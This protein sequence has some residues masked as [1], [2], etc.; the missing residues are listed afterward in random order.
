MCWPGNVDSQWRPA[1]FCMA[2]IRV[3][4]VRRPHR[5]VTGPISN[6]SSS[7]AANA[8]F[9]VWLLCYWLCVTELN[10]TLIWCVLLCCSVVVLRCCSPGWCRSQAASW[11]C[12]PMPTT[13][14][15]ARASAYTSQWHWRPGTVWGLALM[16]SAAAGSS[17][18]RQPSATQSCW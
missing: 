10:I 3:Q 11:W 15:S 16:Q 14:G 18:R 2:C 5:S 7:S 17:T 9:L 13:A 1:C 6:S 12:C 8:L 4:R